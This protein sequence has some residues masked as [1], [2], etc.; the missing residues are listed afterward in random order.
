MLSDDKPHIVVLGSVPS[1][2]LQGIS[3]MSGYP[4]VLD[5]WVYDLALGFRVLEL[6]ENPY[7]AA[8]VQLLAGCRSDRCIQKHAAARVEDHYHC[9]EN[10]LMAWL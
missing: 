1:N 3:P 6:V 10:D 9:L 4:H 7:R 8:L 2:M 5:D